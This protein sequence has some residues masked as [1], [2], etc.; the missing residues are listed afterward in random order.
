[1]KKF[2]K[3]KIT[4]R[5]YFVFPKFFFYFSFVFPFLWVG[6]GSYRPLRR[7]IFIAF[8]LF[9]WAFFCPE[10]SLDLVLAAFFAA[11]DLAAAD[12]PLVFLPRFLCV[13]LEATFFFDP[14]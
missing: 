12:I 13:F 7:R 8:F 10:L 11:L 6:I 3:R 9:L 1:M 4:Y 5:S 14:S 2:G